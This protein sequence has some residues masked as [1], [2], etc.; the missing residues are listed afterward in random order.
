MIRKHPVLRGF[1]LA[2]LLV[3]LVVISLLAVLGL[4][5]FQNQ[6]IRGQDAK[7]K[8][9]FAKLR[10]LFEDYYNDHDCYP[11]M[12]TWNAYNCLDG[13]G[14]QFFAPYLQGQKIPCD[15]V[16]NER[17][18]YITIPESVPANISACSGYK[19]FA[20]LGNKAD[21]DIPGSGCSPDPDKGCG[22]VPYKYNYGISVG[23]TIANPAFDFVAP[24]VSPTPA[25]GPGN[26]FCLAEPN[27]SHT[28]NT[29][30]GLFAPDGTP[31]SEALRAAGCTSFADGALCKQF[32]ETQFETYSCSVS[33]PGCN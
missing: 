20:A 16:T 12:A 27:P 10:V 14:G 32:C 19:L 1:S 5:A 28:C 13:S 15:P 9:D 18:L 33:I 31:C 8:A 29:K 3:V 30:A 23:G 6:M 4:L 24:T 21:P 2:E 17:Y 26:N 22:Y 25:G 7:R 11:Q